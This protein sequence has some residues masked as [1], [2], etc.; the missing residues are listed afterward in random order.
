[1]INALAARCEAVDVITMRA[2]RLAVAP[3]VR[4]YSVGKERGYGE[5]RR[6]VE[7]YRLLF[8]LLRTQ[9]YDACFATCSPCSRRSAR[10]CSNCTACR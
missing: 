7:F 2:G 4:V 1:V 9:R 10:P 6:L 8:R 3:N 5:P